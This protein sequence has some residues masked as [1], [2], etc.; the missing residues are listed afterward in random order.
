[1]ESCLCMN[2][3]VKYIY[4][5][6]QILAS[7]IG[8]FASDMAYDRWGRFSRGNVSRGP[9]RVAP[10][11]TPDYAVTQKAVPAS[12]YVRVVSNW[13]TDNCYVFATHILLVFQQ[14]ILNISIL[15]FIIYRYTY[16]G[17]RAA[18]KAR[19][20]VTHLSYYSTGMLWFKVTHATIGMP[21]YWS[22]V[23]VGL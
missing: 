21:G 23:T 19:L 5:S 3:R 12:I 13:V 4:R 8:L 20:L 6:E 9:S 2:F 22:T 7:C 16:Q 17:I 14:V 11:L 10:L 15:Y 1:M 18:C